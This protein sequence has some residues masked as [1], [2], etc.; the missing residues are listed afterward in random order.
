MV[1]RISPRARRGRSW[2]ARDAEDSRRKGSY[3]L[4]GPSP[5]VYHLGRLTGL[6]PGATYRYEVRVDG[7]P[8][9]TTDWSPGSFT[10]LVPPGELRFRFATVT[11]THVGEDIAGLIGGTSVEGFTW[12]DPERP[13]WRFTN[14]AVVRAINEAQVA[15]VIHKG[16]LTAEAT[17]QQLI[18]AK[19]IFDALEMPWYVVRGN[20]DR[21]HEGTDDFA[22]L[23]DLTPTWR[24]F[25][26]GRHRFVLLDSNQPGTGLP[27]FSDEEFT[28]LVSELVAAREALRPAWVVLHHAASEQAEFFFTLLGAEQTR[29]LEALDAASLARWGPAET[30]PAWPLLALL[31]LAVPGGIWEAPGIGKPGPV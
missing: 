31:A 6:V 5:S 21:A 27:G 29:F 11:D 25:D 2:V 13:Y 3:G 10:T 26:H 14:E 4:T 19:A 8:V 17:P 22:S 16:D 7:D 1:A 12:P 30:T 23:F 20:H 9:P 15:F 28:W 18:D 24:A